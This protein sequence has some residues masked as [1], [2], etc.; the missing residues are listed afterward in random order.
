MSGSLTI[1]ALFFM[2]GGFGVAAVQAGRPSQGARTAARTVVLTLIV[3]G[4]LVSFESW[5][6][7]IRSFSTDLFSAITDS[8]RATSPS[9]ESAPAD[10]P[11]PV[12]STAPAGPPEP[13]TDGGIPTAWLII[14]LAVA[15]ATI[16][17]VGFG[18][19]LHAL[20]QRWRRARTAKQEETKR[21]LDRWTRARTSY[22]RTRDE[23][24]A[25]LLDP[26]DQLW[27]RPLLNDVNEPLTRSF[28]D[29]LADA[30]AAM[31]PDFPDD[32]DRVDAALSAATALSNTWNQA[33]RHAEAHGLLHPRDEQM[34]TA[35][36]RA[37]GLLD[38]ALD[39]AAGASYDAI[40]DKIREI[41]DTLPIRTPD[42]ASVLTAT[43]AQKALE[44][45]S[46]HRQLTAA[47]EPEGM[48]NR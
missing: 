22:R 32:A 1:T 37:R 16:V 34:R 40:V 13:S 33:R 18:V 11:G 26:A 38:Q 23:Y 9:D 30:E 15:G 28:L 25:F 31:D 7:L 24:D 47:H 4:L 46:D 42:V 43:A 17:L 3:G 29:A 39:P 12:E 10:P 21:L 48:M 45:G 5:Y 6:G 20:T 19:G 35:L 36:R 27:G 44:R 14:I 41:M 8:S 2:I